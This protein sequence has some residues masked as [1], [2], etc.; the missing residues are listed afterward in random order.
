[1]K[2]PTNSRKKLVIREV[3]PERFTDQAKD[4]FNPDFQ[5]HI[6][7]TYE[8]SRS[9][10]VASKFSSI[11]AEFYGRHDIEYCFVPIFKNAHNYGKQ[12]FS[13]LGFAPTENFSDKKFIIFF[14]EPVNRWVSGICQWF[15]YASTLE[16]TSLP[17]DYKIDNV[18]MNMLFSTVEVDRHTQK[19]LD[20]LTGLSLQKCVFFNLDDP[21]FETDLKNFVRD[22]L[23]ITQKLPQLKP[24]NVLENDVFKLE[25]QKQLL[26]ALQS[27][28]RKSIIE[29]YYNE[30]SFLYNYM[31]KNP[32]RIYT[33]PGDIL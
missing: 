7:I 21:N 11:D 26:N 29:N 12:F 1:M 5:R 32:K 4:N 2:K 10:I 23:G 6:K 33:N 15:N 22:K 19:Q 25:I 17:L 9:G 14:R 13:S 20:F 16:Q 28:V 8:R 31:F 3:D 18:M 24:S 30:D 27:N